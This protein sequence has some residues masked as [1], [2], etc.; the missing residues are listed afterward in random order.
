MKEIEVTKQLP[1]VSMNFDEVKASLIETTEKYKN[2]VVT[3]EGLKDCKATQKELA[4]LRNKIDSYRKD[5]KREMERPIKSFESQCKEL[6]KLIADAEAPIKD[7]IAVFDNKRRLEKEEIAKELIQIAIQEHRIEEEYASKLTVLDKY[8]NLNCSKKS[9]KED[10]EVR[11]VSLKQQQEADK[12]KRAMLEA[13]IES[14]L[15]IVNKDLKTP[16]KAEQFKKYINMGWDI[17][18]IVNQINSEAEL[19]KKAEMVVEEKSKEEVQIPVD[20]K[21]PEIKETKEKKLFINMK[22][23]DTKERMAAL[24]KFLKSN[25]YAYEVIEQRWI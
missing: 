8:L 6:I 4:G 17:K 15:E 12:A 10:I 7:G 22:V 5:V 13:T 9:V 25:G 2:I 18:L 3:E 20:L 23:Q 21:V 24:S 14:T 11:A 19:I 16:L 1:I